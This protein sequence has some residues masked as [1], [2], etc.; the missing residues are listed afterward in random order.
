M[1]RNEAA[2]CMAVPDAP[3]QLMLYPRVEFSVCPLP[4]RQSQNIP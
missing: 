4:L 1:K 2:L 3:L